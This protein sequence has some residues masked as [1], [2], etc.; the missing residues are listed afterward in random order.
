MKYLLVLGGGSKRNEVWGN[1]CA[2]AYKEY[3]DMTFFIHYDHWGTEEKNVNIEAELEKI[4]A[5]VEG[6]AEGKWY[7]CAKSIGSILTLMATARGTIT[8]KK[9]I[10]FGMPFSVVGESV[11]H[12]DF[13]I[14]SSCAV[15]T[16]A[17][18]NHN[19]PTALYDVTKEVLTT[20]AS[21][22]TLH[23]LSGDN[24]DYLD[25]ASYRPTIESFLSLS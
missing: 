22:I 6:A 1:E 16:L 21:S 17:Y 19:D 13:S 4:K 25:F 11:L 2:A 5:T 14:V 3:F 10:F 18:H 12:N 23:T 24:H 9:C 20:H 7:V 15:P 8:P